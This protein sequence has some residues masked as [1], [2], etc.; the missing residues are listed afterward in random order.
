MMNRN[1]GQ[2]WRACL[3]ALVVA[4]AVAGTGRPARAWQGPPPDDGSGVQVLTQGPIHEGF[5][6]PMVYDP[7]PGPMIPRQ[8]PAPVEELPPDQKPE[9]DNVQWIPGYWA[10]DDSRNDFLWVSGIWRAVPPGRQW[11]P[12]YWNAADQGA[13]WVP[14]VWAPLNPPGEPDQPAP[15]LQYLPTP[16][17]SIEGGPNV[18]PPSDD[19]TWSPGTWFWTDNRYVWRPGYWVPVRPDWLWV[20]AHY[21]WSP[22]GCLFVDGYW[23]RPL[24]TRGQMFAPVYFQ[25]PVYTQPN[26]TYT[27]AVGLVAGALMSNLFVRPSYSSYYFGDYYGSNSAQS[28]IYPWYSYHQSRYGYDPI[29]AYASTV[30]TRRDP[31]WVDQ[32]RESYRYRRDHPEARPAR[33]YAEQTRIVNTVTNVNNV[34]N[35]NNFNNVTNVNTIT[36]VNNVRNL[37]LARPLAQMASNRQSPVRFARVDEGARRE[38]RTQATQVREFH[39]QRVQAERQAARAQPANPAAAGAPPRTLNLPR[40]PIAAAPVRRPEG[41]PPE[42]Q[43]ARL[44]P[45]P[46]PTAPRPDHAVRPA[47]PGREVVRHE[48]LLDQKPPEHLQPIRPGY[49]PP[50]SP[51]AGAG[52]GPGRPSPAEASRPLPGQPLPGQPLPGAPPRP[53]AQPLPGPR[54]VEPIRPEVMKPAPR[55]TPTPVPA[56][57]PEPVKPAPRPEPAKPAA[58]EPRPEPAKP[59]APEPPRGAPR[60]GVTGA[61]AFGVPNR[62]GLPPGN[63]FPGQRAPGQGGPMPTNPYGGHPGVAP[64]VNLPPGQGGPMPTAPNAGYVAPGYGLPPGQPPKPFGQPRPGQPA[65]GLPGIPPGTPPGQPRP[66]LPGQPLPGQ[67]LPSQPLPGQPLPGQPLPGQPLPG[68]ARPPGPARPELPG[69]RPQ[70]GRV[71]PPRPARP[72]Q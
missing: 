61:E 21:V 15:P 55:P 65:P 17:P 43:H 16:P 56:P 1:T 70:P 49:R 28:G 44:A 34:N 24:A 5:A 39:A 19:V 7:K 30:N 18:P 11:V 20:P 6:E 42:Q 8:P 59:A 54:P 36:T 38:I 32:V 25:Q 51:G 12:G 52:A 23:D 3:P 33:T 2:L 46:L 37:E 40:S 60:P 67:P 26:Y 27:P 72:P 63:A 47:P 66:G 57:G 13:Q 41:Q 22:N 45:P 9:G 58:P 50:L 53:G 64:R 29:Y 4:C 35:V 10:W 14:G 71:E 69:V 62:P 68:A 48:P 31:Q